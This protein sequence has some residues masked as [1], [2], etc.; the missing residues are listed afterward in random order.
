MKLAAV[1]DVQEALINTSIN[2]VN[3]YHAKQIKEVVSS[4]GISVAALCVPA[5][6]AQ[7]VCNNL[8]E[9]GVKGILNYSKKRLKTPADVEV[10]YQQMVCTFMQ[11]SFSVSQADDDQ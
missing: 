9:A 4:F 5:Q 2:N 6:A 11:L 7:K 1:F 8:V 10:Q 3:I